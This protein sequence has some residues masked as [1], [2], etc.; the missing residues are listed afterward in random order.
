[1]G[2]GP[3]TTGVFEHKRQKFNGRKKARGGR[4]VNQRQSL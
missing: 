2:G 3:T 1:M 4:W